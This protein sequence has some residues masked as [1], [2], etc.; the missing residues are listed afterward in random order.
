KAKRKKIASLIALTLTLNLSSNYIAWANDSDKNLKNN[1]V[2]EEMTV[3]NL[4]SNAGFESIDANGKPLNW[5]IWQGGSE[6]VGIDLQNAFEGN[7]CAYIVS[8]SSLGYV[9]KNL[10]P[11][12]TYKYTAY[13][14]LK[15]TSDSAIVG[16]K[17]FGGEEIKK[18]VTGT[19]YEKHTITFTTGNQTTAEVY[20]WD[21]SGLSNEGK[22][23]IDKVSVEEQPYE[24]DVEVKLNVSELLLSQQE[25]YELN[26]KILPDIALNK[27]VKYKTSDES[28]VTVTEKG[29]IKALNKGQ[30]TI[31]AT[32]EAGGIESTCVVTVTENKQP[33]Y[34][35]TDNSEWSLVMEDEFNGD[36]LDTTKW[37]VRGKEYKTY[38]RSDMVSVEEGKLKL[39]IEREPDGQVVL[40][41][42]DNHDEDLTTNK[43][44]F[45]Q[46]YGFFEASAKIPPTEQTYFAFWMFN[47]PGVFNVDGTG[48]DGLEIDITE[49]VFQGDYTESTLHWDGYDRGHKSTSSHAKPAPNIHDGFHRYGLEW[50]EDT[51]KFY[52]DGKLTWTYSGVAV[53]WVKEILIFSSG[54]GMWGQGDINNANLPYTAEVD[55]VRVYKRDNDSKEDTTNPMVYGL[56]DIK[57]GI[58]SKDNLLDGVWAIDNKD[59]ED[60]LTKLIS[61][62]ES[63]IDRSKVGEYIASYEVTDKAGNTERAEREIHVVND[64]ELNNKIFNG[65]FEKDY[66]DKWTVSGKE[67]EAIDSN[68]AGV[69]NDEE[70]GTFAYIAPTTSMEQF[71]TLKPNTTYRLKVKAKPE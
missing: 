65:V 33:W 7:N 67:G 41:R 54:L 42:I 14:K 34:P 26:A 11:N 61:I 30:A 69:T 36:T 38:H 59:D 58:N 56:D 48:R 60:E 64:D 4:I 63:S 9:L 5:K 23:Y 6:E 51:L 32:P 40:G 28:I 3:E 68:K 70:N 22:A 71:I 47:Y 50:T 21:G 57:I 20:L 19:E 39:G 52:F 35:E 2:I 13:V 62:D 18:T 49:T 37:T 1:N 17:D 10:K 43:T 12:T 53:P 15:N 44:K 55:W 16:V 46:K 66:L 24:G 25:E 45:S 8:N 29:K 31:T 27:N